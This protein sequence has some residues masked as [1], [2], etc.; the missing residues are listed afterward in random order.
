[1]SDTREFVVS[2]ADQGLRLD[3]IL[4]RQ[5]PD[6]SRSQLQRQIRC[7]ELSIGARTS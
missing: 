4:A 6:W 5:I 2:S 3:V 7:G 1:M